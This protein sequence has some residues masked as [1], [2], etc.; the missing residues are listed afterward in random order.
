MGAAT[1]SVS[2]PPRSPPAD[3]A[4]G[5]TENRSVPSKARKWVVAALADITTVLPFP[6]LS[7]DSDNGS[8]SISYHLLR[9]CGERQITFIRSRSDNSNDGAHV[10]QRNWAV[11][12]TVVGYHRYDTPAE[13]LLL[14]KIWT[15]QSTGRTTSWPSRS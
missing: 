6:L 8:Q 9:W 11:V 4:T 12:R 10:E 5:W 3:I 13:L 7:L 1:R 2:T 15:L 14:N